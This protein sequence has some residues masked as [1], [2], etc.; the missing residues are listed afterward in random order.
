MQKKAFFCFFALFLVCLAGKA[1]V[2]NNSLGLNP[3]RLKWQQIKTDKVQI[4]FPAGMA[5]QGQRAANLVHYLYDHHNESVGEKRQRITMILQNQT[6]IPNGFVTVGPFRSE[7]Y[8]TPPQFNVNGAGDWFDLLIIHEYRHVKQFA[9]SKRGITKLAKNIFGSWTW[10]GFFGLTLPRWYLEGDATMTET[11]LTNAGRGRLPEFDME[12][13]SLALSGIHYK[14]DKAYAG[15]FR[16]YVPSFYN[17]GYYMT[18]YARREFGNDVWNKVV[19][20]AVQ[21]KG[22]FYP[23]GRNMQ[24]HMGLRPRKLYEKTFKELDENWKQ[25][26]TEKGALQDES[27]IIQQP[28]KV[29]TDYKFPQ[30]L[31][32]NTLIVEKS[33]FNEIR[34]FYKLTSTKNAFVEPSYEENGERLFSPG[35]NVGSNITLSVNKGM[36]VWS[37]LTYHERWGGKNYSIIRMK[38]EGEANPNPRK[39]TTRSRYFAPSLSPDNRQIVAVHV[40]DTLRY[41]IVLLSV[42]TGKE[43]SRLPNPNNYF[44]SFPV[45]SPDAQSI[46]AIT[47]QG[48]YNWLSEINVATGELRELTARTIWQLSYPC[49]TEKH[50]F[51]SSAY[52]GTNNIFALKR[53]SDSLFQVT[54]HALGAYFPAVSPN[55]KYLAYSGF[56]AMGYDIYEMVLK[57]E[58]WQ[59]YLPKTENKLRF[60]MPI[61]KQEGGESIISKVGKETFA[62]KKFHKA[63]GLLNVHSFLPYAYPPEIG[64]RLL[65]DNKFSTFSGEAESHYNINEKTWRHGIQFN[66]AEFYPI[67]RA[68]FLQGNRAR[69]FINYRQESDTAFVATIYN[70]RWQE[71]D[72]YA[73]VRIPLNLTRGTA[74]N[75]LT[76]STD[77][78]Y[79]QL[80]TENRFLDNSRNQRFRIKNTLIPRDNPSFFQPRLQNQNI[81]TLD[82]RLRMSSQ[83]TT[84]HRQFLPRLAAFSDIRYLT[85]LGK[86][87]LKGNTFLMRLDLYMPSLWKTHSI[88]ANLAY[89]YEKFTN[90]YKFRNLFFYPRGYNF[91]PF[92]VDGVGKVAINYA[93]PLC[94]PDI[95]LGSLVFLKRIKA[96]AF[97]DG[98]IINFNS[99]Y[100][101]FTKRTVGGSYM[102]SMGVDITF[103]MRVLR[104]LELEIGA[105]YSY[106]FD[107]ELVRQS[108]PHN[109]QF[110]FLGIGI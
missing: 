25:E 12:Y 34:T 68:G 3:S 81:H 79:L 93:L 15:S 57:P 54:N 2:P 53:G 52:T 73:G 8:T 102:R 101:P 45:F 19:N 37:E 60:F 71:R 86:G 17:L 83:V 99:I 67:F 30:Y 55:R 72:F 4:I 24:K 74:F 98:A 75:N 14:Y 64:G 82:F 95:K 100:P 40:P 36:M 28:K 96:N 63:S 85:T 22:L 87:D 59:P 76:F 77:Y 109:I 29:Y 104:L 48:E 1:Q 7:C 31:N 10:G 103:D 78:H 35:I 65:A 91:S 5:T 89:Q 105:R 88:S 41:S 56:S 62:V 16:N 84:A 107:N 38:N 97:F 92:Y 18:G 6:T 70:E 50:I 46:I 44:F 21:F 9:N 108:S 94:Y 69:G 42:G 39:I 61:V 110:L 33:S 47:Q 32:E 13:K 51:F 26:T 20:D 66:Y 43:I 27:W 49:V 58:N 80:Q 11:A 90:N 23:F 106:L